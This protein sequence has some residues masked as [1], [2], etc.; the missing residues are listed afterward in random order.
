MGHGLQCDLLEGGG[1][2][3]DHI[4]ACGTDF[5]A[6]LPQMLVLSTRYLLTGMSAI[7]EM[8]AAWLAH[9]SPLPI[10][11]FLLLLFFIAPH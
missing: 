10:E 9:P 4:A 3:H 8:F 11:I 6:K 1:L 7:G 2:V 5:T